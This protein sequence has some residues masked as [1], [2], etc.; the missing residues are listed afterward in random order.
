MIVAGRAVTDVEWP[1]LDSCFEDDGSFAFV[2]QSDADDGWV[3]QAVSAEESGVDPEEGGEWCAVIATASLRA[4][5]FLRAAK[6]TKHR[7]AKR[8]S[9]SQ[10]KVHSRRDGLEAEGGTATAADMATGSMPLAGGAPNDQAVVG[11]TAVDAGKPLSDIRFRRREGRRRG[12]N[13]K[14]GAHRAAAQGTTQE[15]QRVGQRRQGERY[16]LTAFEMN[17]GDEIFSLD[18]SKRWDTAE[19]ELAH[20]ATA[21]QSRSLRDGRIQTTFLLEPTHYVEPNAMDADAAFALRTRLYIVQGQ[22]PKLFAVLNTEPPRTVGG[23]LLKAK[24][25]AAS[26]SHVPQTAIVRTLNSAAA[27]Q[28]R[29]TES[30]T[31][32]LGSTCLVTDFSTQGRHP[33]TRR[34][35][36]RVF[37][38]GRGDVWEHEA[39]QPTDD[40]QPGAT[41]R[42]TGPW[43]T[44]VATEPYIKWLTPQYVTKYELLWRAE[45]GRQWN[46]LGQFRG[47]TDATS[48]VA[49]SFTSV[50]GG[51]RARYLRVM[52]LETIGG[53]A[54]RIGVYGHQGAVPVA[55][56]RARAI[57]G[58]T[59]ESTEGSDAH[60][61]IKYSLTSVT[62]A[63]AC[64]HFIPR[65]AEPSRRCRC[66][67]CCFVSP[68]RRQALRLTA[69]G[70]AKQVTSER[71]L[72]SLPLPS[73]DYALFDSHSSVEATCR[74]SRT[75]W[76]SRH[77]RS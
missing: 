40:A 47:N 36:Q 1:P 48:E 45:N 63:G 56:R 60:A 38:P 34:Y 73:P 23:D 58:P 17:G 27:W 35:P 37:A 18:R 7:A 20:H 39:Y 22:K 61:L 54:L 64:M 72:D 28:C 15:L 3:Y 51:L 65:G 42:Y 66:E 14:S 76:K 9:E 29:G 75:P 12:L 4:L 53:G 62:D 31:I 43:W 2:Q 70:E 69:Q 21:S 6:S 26:G 68:S 16:F 19:A 11:H 59:D 25:A 52:P 71:A 13:G 57:N 67:Y 30:L 50:R 24:L 46:S 8:C 44:V 33:P 55:A 5:N 77:V 49:H 32:D 10:T 74:I 41:D